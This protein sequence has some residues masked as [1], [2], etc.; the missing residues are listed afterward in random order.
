[1]QQ[2]CVGTFGDNCGGGPCM[3][4]YYGFGCRNRCNC[5]KVQYCDRFRG[6]VNNTSQYN[7]FL[8]HGLRKLDNQF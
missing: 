2:A 6:C 7:I 3:E 1:M 5:T 8:Y 4:G